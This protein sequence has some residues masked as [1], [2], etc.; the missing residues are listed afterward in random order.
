MA[1]N[2]SS[3][4][5][6]V[7]PEPFAAGEL[8]RGPA[9]IPARLVARIRSILF[10][11]H[12]S[13]TFVGHVGATFFV[14]LVLIAVGFA[15]SVMTAR[16]LGPAGRG[17]YT[18]AV[19]LGAIGSQFGNLGLHSAN[20]Y[21]IGR[22]KS[23]LPRLFSNALT[24]G[25]G[26]GG[27]IALLL[28]ILFHLHPSW[29]PV[30]G[31]LLLGGLLLIPATLLGML[32]QNLLLAV[33]EVKWYNIAEL[34]SR[35][36]IVVGLVGIWLVM[37]GVRPAEVVLCALSATCLSFCIDAIRL[38][39]ITRAL[40]P[41]SFSLLRS[42]ASYGLRAYLTC[43]AGYVVLKSDILLVK[44]L[45]GDTATGL[46]SLASSMTDFIYTFPTVVG[47]IL[48]PMLSSTATMEG[49]WRRARKTMAGIALIMSVISLTAAL[50]ATPAIRIAFGS[51]YLPAVPAFLVLCVAIVFYGANSV[52]SIF[53]SSCGQ[54]W[55]SVFVWIGGAVLNIGLNLVVIPRW[56]IV[57]A[58][59]SSLITYMALFFVQYAIAP[60]Y[61][62]N[63]LATAGAEVAA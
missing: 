20:T 57:G 17:L 32:L 9:S 62:R 18:A 36:G 35:A 39:S 23:L 11:G 56:G 48:F 5:V 49:R 2:E 43:L 29:A 54:P 26:L 31:Y 6:A 50:L 51:R 55:F 8:S 24:V 63:R 53:F 45:A 38:L 15:I 13:R 27:G 4:V 33:R 1:E 28:G 10:S 22:D 47:M 42:Q 34:T 58:A 59:Y 21:F 12:E 40:P 37:R 25:I 14:R 19:V 60:R 41:P 44:Y 46:Y 16:L 52:I 61:A 3:S 30:R 7:D